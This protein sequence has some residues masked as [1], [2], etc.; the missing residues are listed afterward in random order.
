VSRSS[1][2]RKRIAGDRQGAAR[3]DLKLVER[4]VVARVIESDNREP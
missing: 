2:A 4:D 1:R 3:R